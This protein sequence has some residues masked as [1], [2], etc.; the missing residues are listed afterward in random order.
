MLELRIPTERVSPGTGH[1]TMFGPL[2]RLLP[3][4]TASGYH[5]DQVDVVLVTH[6]HPDHVGGI[7]SLDGN[8]IFPNADIIASRIEADFWFSAEAEKASLERD[9][10][11]FGVA[12]E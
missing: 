7:T 4:L 2:G 9:R 6:L 8:R 5:P 11:F 10:E 1:H 12:S 3:N